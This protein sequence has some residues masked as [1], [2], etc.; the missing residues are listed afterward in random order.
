MHKENSERRQTIIHSQK[1]IRKP[2]E[3]AFYSVT[4]ITEQLLSDTRNLGFIVPTVCLTLMTLTWPPNRF[5]SV[6]L[7]KGATQG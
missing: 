6:I 7:F 4:Q 2:F 1:Q 5:L 3:L